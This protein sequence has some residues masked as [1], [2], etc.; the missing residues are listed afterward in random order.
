FYLL[1][2]LVSVSMQAQIE[3]TPLEVC[4]IGND[5]Y[6]GVMLGEKVSEIFN[7]SF[8]QNY[9]LNFYETYADAQNNQNWIPDALGTYYYSMVPP[10]YT[11]YARSENIENGTVELY[12]FEVI[13]LNMPEVGLPISLVNSEG[14][15][16]L[17]ENIPLISNG[18]NYNITFF[19]TH[20][21]AQYSGTPILNPESYTA[22]SSLQPIYVKVE[23]S[24]GCFIITSFVLV[25]GDNDDIVNGHDIVDIPDPAFKNKLL[26]TDPMVGN[27][28]DYNGDLIFLDSND[29][30][31]IQ[32]SE[33]LSI[34][35]LSVQNANIQDMTGI[36]A[37]VNLTFLRCRN[38][39]ITELNTSSLVNLTILECQNNNLTELDLSN[40]PDLSFLNCNNNNI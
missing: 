9:T 28:F 16:D 29:D 37:F 5:G 40:N 31:E 11:I 2:I 17:T 22:I 36:E 19:L 23:S 32:V 38:N 8:P 25:T 30:G 12:S 35:W 13:F 18:N 10:P 20:E 21:D 34:Y 7:G 14:I 15:F 24:N 4:D 1:T 26:Q 27:A 39:Q 3:L 6:E 33:A